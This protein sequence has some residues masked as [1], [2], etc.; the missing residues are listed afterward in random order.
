MAA[1]VV[2]VVL[3]VI[4]THLIWLDISLP[5]VMLLFSLVVFRNAPF[6]F[7][8]AHHV[9]VMAA[10]ITTSV[11]VGGLVFFGREQSAAGAYFLVYMIGLGYSAFILLFLVALAIYKILPKLRLVSTYPRKAEVRD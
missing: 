10:L 8:W 5:F 3:W 1:L 9:P 6:H 11:G 2:F 4:R 7:R